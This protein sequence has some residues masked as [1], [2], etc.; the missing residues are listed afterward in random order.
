MFEG[1]RRFLA[2]QRAA[3]VAL[4]L[5][6]EN[7]A[8]GTEERMAAYLRFE[9]MA[10]EVYRPCGYRWAYLYDT[11]AHSRQMLR[12]VGQVRPRLLE[13]GGREIRNGDYLEPC[14]FQNSGRPSPRSS[15]TRTG[16]GHCPRCRRCLDRWPT[17][18]QLW[19]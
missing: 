17:A 5:L 13:P 2:E 6:A 4:R 15:T 10:N 12:Q 9:A 8:L 16:H 11:C 19:P 3:G 7:D 14:G 1:F 18:S